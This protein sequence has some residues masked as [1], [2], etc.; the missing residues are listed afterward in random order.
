[1]GPVNFLLLG[2][3][4]GQFFIPQD[5]LRQVPF[6]RIIKMLKMSVGS[7][8][9]SV[10]CRRMLSQFAKTSSMFEENARL[11]CLHPRALIKQR[12]RYLTTAPYVLTQD[13]R[14][15]FMAVFPDVVREIVEHDKTTPEL[16]NLYTKV[17]QYNVAGGKKLRG[18]TVVYS[19]RQLVN[20]E[21]LTP[22][23]IR[24]SQILGWCVEMMQ[25]FFVVLD[26]IVDESTQRRGRPCW[27]Q[28]PEV[29]LKAVCHALLIEGA[30]YK[31]LKKYLSGTEAY[32]PILE[33]FHSMTLLTTF[34]Q[35]LD[36]NTAD[37]SQVSFDK[38]NMER[39]NFI[40]THKTAYYT[41]YLP[42]ATAMY[43]AG[44]FNPE[45]HRQAKSILV[46]IG[47]Y[48]QVQDDYLDVFGEETETGKDGTDIQDGKCSWLAVVALQRASP[49][50]EKI[51]KEHFGK[52]GENHVKA[53]KDLYIE[54]GL[55]GLYTIYE[56][57]TY[58]MINTHIQ[59]LSAGLPHDLFFG[60]LDRIHKRNK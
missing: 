37:Q 27:H 57:E 24:L 56:Q 54:M 1:M 59:Q 36:C 2:Q 7:R 31:L 9:L 13:D 20:P 33:L 4:Q 11:T 26:D 53:I 47:R 17:L 8:M 6:S 29:G 58:N 55:P 43:L 44:M 42:M 16:A 39:Y 15:D 32:L 14:R 45:Q 3:D 51:F 46:K 23:N 48:F 12:S 21:Q 35:V 52:V 18:L 60:L 19:Y 30:Q 22:E 41:F 34:G 40:T 5:Q 25:A 28:L 38:I 50:Q 49:K 10:N